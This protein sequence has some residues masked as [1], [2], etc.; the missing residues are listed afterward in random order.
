MHDTANEI[1]VVLRRCHD[2]EEVLPLRPYPDGG[3]GKTMLFARLERAINNQLEGGSATLGRYG[4][5]AT[6]A[7]DQLEE[8]ARLLAAGDRRS[9]SSLIAAVANSLIG[10]AETQRLLDP[11]QPRQ[12]RPGE[13]AWL[14]EIRGCRDCHQVC[15]WA[16]HPRGQPLL[17]EGGN[18]DAD[19][20]FVAEAPNYEDTVDPRKGRLTVDPD[21]DPSGAFIY[22]LLTRE[23][24][25]R[26]DRVLFT[27]AMLCLPAGGGGDHPGRAVARKQ[28]S[29]RLRQTI[30]NV[31]PR[32]VVTVGAAALHAVKDIEKHR[33]RLKDAAGSQH[34][35]FGRHLFP[36]YHTSRRARST[37][38]ETQQREDW[39]ALRT[40][41]DEAN[42]TAPPG[43]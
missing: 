25:L 4:I 23:L 14:G 36:V 22:S 39:Q 19:V 38:K 2:A 30:E 7:R 31:D 5:W 27:N 41:L 29:H 11:H 24:G 3:L 37:R 15:P 6:T 20:L 9:S 42:R 1:R 13:P 12:P 26:P 40:I 34:P 28:C 18:L 33:L 10:F 16:V 35:W 32:V 17:H 8:A 21:T 43:S